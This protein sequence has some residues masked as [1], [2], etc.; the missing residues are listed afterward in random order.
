MTETANGKKL[1][2]I[3]GGKGGI[4]KSIFTLGLGI[5]LARLG[6]KVI[7]MDA[8]LGAPICIPSWASAIPAIPWR[9]SC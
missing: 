7:L 5:S 9:I 4:G 1:W 6:K 2:A 8:D 3:G